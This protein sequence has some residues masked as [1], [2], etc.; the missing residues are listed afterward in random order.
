[1]VQFPV[2]P[3]KPV[4]LAVFLEVTKV[5][6]LLSK[7]KITQLHQNAEV[8]RAVIQLLQIQIQ[9]LWVNLDL[10]SENLAK[11]I[12]QLCLKDQNMKKTKMTT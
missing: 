3:V 4:N 11:K 8:S 10:T 6:P 5:M 1:M 2:I 7:I 12:L 9:F